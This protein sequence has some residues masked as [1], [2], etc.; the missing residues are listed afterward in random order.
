MGGIGHIMSKCWGYAQR[1]WKVYGTTVFGTGQEAMGAAYKKALTTKNPLKGQ[2]Y[3]DIWSGTKEA[4]RAAEAHAAKEAA[5][6]GS[7]WKSTK[8]SIKTFPKKIAQGWKVGGYKAAKAGNIKAF[9]NIK[10]AFSAIGKKMPLIGSLML[11]AFEL[12]NI[13]KATANEGIVQGGAEVV[14]AGARIGGATLVAAL[15]TAIGGPI[16]GIVGFMVGDWLT[17]KIVGKSYSEKKAIEQ[18]KLA[19]VQQAQADATNPQTTA[20]GTATTF[21]GLTPEMQMYQQMMYQNQN[22]MNDDFMYNAYKT[23]TTPQLDVKA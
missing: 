9:G 1:G 5:K 22:G 12:P 11:V 4:G 17:S 13:I 15:G 8:N 19:L 6:H 7:F 16:G 2:F 3:K 20:S 10:G 18:E 21:K 14:K 23:N